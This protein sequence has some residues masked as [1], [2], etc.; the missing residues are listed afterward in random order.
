LL[1]QSLDQWIHGLRLRLDDGEFAALG[2]LYLAEG[3]DELPGETVVRVLLAD[4]EHL[5]RLEPGAPG[6]DERHERLSEVLDDFRRLRVL[7]G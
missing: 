3:T 1:D 4:L 6:W 7:L 2:R 5:G